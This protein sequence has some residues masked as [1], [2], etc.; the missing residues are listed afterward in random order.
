MK[1]EVKTLDAASA[2]EIDL[3]DEIFGLEVRKD[4][5][6]RVITWQLANRRA[7]ARA[8]RE[9]SDVSLTGKKMYKQKGTGGARHGNRAAPQFRK[10]GKAHGPRARTFEQGLNKKIRA[11]GLKTALSAKQAEGKLIVVD[12][13]SLSDAKTK[14]LAER[15]TELGIRSGLFIDGA[16]VD[17]GFRLACANLPKID[18]LPAIGANVYD[19][20]NHETLVLT[21]SAIEQLEAR[22]HG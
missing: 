9:R 13:L 14:V 5:L 15:L 19:I 11:L 4:I 12:T 20:L 10:G 21:R 2:G 3:K 16:T 1:I 18:A 6:H 8:A 22:F 17:T 7:P